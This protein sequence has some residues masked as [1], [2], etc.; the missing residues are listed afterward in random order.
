MLYGG[1][2]YRA[3]A[4]LRAGERVAVLQ[5]LWISHW[6]KPLLQ[7]DQLTDVITPGRTTGN[8]GLADLGLVVP[9]KYLH[10]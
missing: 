6:L 5:S 4:Y 3:Q 2:P 10:R 7:R 8:S 9:H 1:N